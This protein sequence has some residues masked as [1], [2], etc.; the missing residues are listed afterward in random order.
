MLLLVTVLQFGLSDRQAAQA[1][2]TRID[3][4]YAIGAELTDTGLNYSVLSDFRSR[5]LEGG[6][7]EDVFERVL[8]TAGARGLLNTRG[9]ARTDSARCSARCGR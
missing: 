9:Q 1:V 3:W 7:S 2:R 4:K 6:R 8:Q 5:L